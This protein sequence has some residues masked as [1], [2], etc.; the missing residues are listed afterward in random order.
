[1]VLTCIKLS[2]FKLSQM[3]SLQCDSFHRSCKT[4]SLGAEVS[5]PGLSRRKISEFF[6]VIVIVYEKEPSAIIRA[7]QNYYIQVQS[8]LR[9][10]C[11]Q[12]SVN[13][14]T[15]MFCFIFS[16]KDSL[17]VRHQT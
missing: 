7:L 8:H 3:I 17:R 9:E 1:M 6:L 4:Y 10:Y 2:F 11:T 13:T 5:Y 12:F 16:P 15:S 14:V